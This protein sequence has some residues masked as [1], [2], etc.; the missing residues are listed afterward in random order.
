MII[1]ATTGKKLL[2]IETLRGADLQGADLRGAVGNSKEIQTVQTK[3]WPIVLTNHFMQI[4]CEQHSY[5][6]WFGFSDER[7]HEM[8]SKA[9]AWWKVWKP[10]IMQ[11]IKE[12]F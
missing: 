3:L 9:L 4:G 7:I 11:I 10:I 8:S 5:S 2:E 6:D 1:Y 12:S